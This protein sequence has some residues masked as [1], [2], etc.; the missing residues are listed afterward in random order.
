MY[1]WTKMV[2]VEDEKKINKYNTETNVVAFVCR[3]KK[4]W[5]DQWIDMFVVEIWNF[6]FHISLN[7]LQEYTIGNTIWKR[8]Q[9]IIP[10]MNKT[11]E[12]D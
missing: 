10:L 2:G 6:V 1:E 8:D 7:I 12:T 5:T 3:A 9:H 11:H 4:P